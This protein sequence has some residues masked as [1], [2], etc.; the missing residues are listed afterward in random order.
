MQEQVHT[1][2]EKKKTTVLLTEELLTEAE[3][4]LNGRV[5]IG[6]MKKL[7]HQQR[8]NPQDLISRFV[9]KVVLGIGGSLKQI[10]EAMSH[11][12]HII[13]GRIQRHAKIDEGMNV[14]LLLLVSK[15]HH[16]G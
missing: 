7:H 14:K 16:I 11:P 8:L 4:V 12:F 10:T 5:C 6:I 15:S 13:P 3:I 1:F 9:W 2:P